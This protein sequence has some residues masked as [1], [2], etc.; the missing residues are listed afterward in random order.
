MLALIE[1]P[2]VSDY[3]I[4]VLLPAAVLPVNAV[5]LYRI[6]AVIYVDAVR[7]LVARR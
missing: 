2:W 1:Y 5:I 6:A 4:W 3:K 7:V